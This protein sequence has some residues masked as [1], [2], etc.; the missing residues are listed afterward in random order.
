ILKFSTL[1]TSDDLFAILKEFGPEHATAI[2]ARNLSGATGCGQPVTG[3]PVASEQPAAAAEDEEDGPLLTAAAATAAAPT[4]AAIA[5][6]EPDRA[7]AAKSEP[8]ALG[9]YFLNAASPERRLLL[10]NLDETAQGSSS[11]PIATAAKDAIHALE[12]A[13]LQRR[14]DV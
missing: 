2:G 1:L 4:P 5:P 13:A 6:A 7:A 9:D 14:P 3:E 8:L 12:T 10:A 11:E